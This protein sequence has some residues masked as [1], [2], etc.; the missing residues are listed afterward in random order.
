MYV[1]FLLKGIEPHC[2]ECKLCIGVYIFFSKR[3]DSIED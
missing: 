1:F 3:C 2:D